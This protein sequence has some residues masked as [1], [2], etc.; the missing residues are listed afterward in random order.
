MKLIQQIDTAFA[1]MVNRKNA[2]KP[3]DVS[4]GYLLQMRH[5]L[6]NNINISLDTKLAFLAKA[7]YTFDDF[8]FTKEDLFSFTEHCV[9]ATPAEKQQ[10]Y[11]YLLAQWR[12]SRVS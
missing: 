5:K 7:G 2:H 4:Y 8:E 12:K 1:E 9:T 6:K 3:L 10:G 11:E